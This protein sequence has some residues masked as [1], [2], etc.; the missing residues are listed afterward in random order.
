[1]GGQTR[2]HD[3]GGA[4]GPPHRLQENH[5]RDVRDPVCGLHP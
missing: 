1:M 5:V 4:H 2:R 3:S